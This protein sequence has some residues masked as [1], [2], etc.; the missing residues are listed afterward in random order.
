[1]AQEKIYIKGFRSFAKSP[2][3]PAFVVGSLV[4]DISD[5]KEFVNSNVEHLTEYNGKKQLK[6][7]MLEGQKGINFV[8]DTYKKPENT[9]QQANVVAKTDKTNNSTDGDLPF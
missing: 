6:V 3:A 4:I 7:Q 9:I 2:N 1:M 5:F 8:L